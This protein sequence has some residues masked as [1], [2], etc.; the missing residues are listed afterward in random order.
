MELNEK[1]SRLED[2]VK[3]I[4]NEVQAVLLDIRESYLN[5]ENP[6][7][8]DVSSPTLHSVAAALSGQMPGV[9]PAV[10]PVKPPQASLP[11]DDDEDEGTEVDEQPAAEL[12]KGDKKVAA[13]DGL[14]ASKEVSEAM[15]SEE[16]PEV[17]E[18]QESQGKKN[19]HAPGSGK[20]DLVTIAGLTKWVSG[21]VGTFG[22]ARTETILDF[23][24]LAGQLPA[25]LKNT[26]V[27]FVN[28]AP[29]AGSGN[30]HSLKAN[31]LVVSV[32]ELEGLL[33]MNSHSDEL[34]L[35]A[36]VCQEVDP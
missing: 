16:E 31:Q 11:V 12:K 34:T 15:R 2:E 14:L 10:Q 3:V 19:G 30:G 35:L 32:V 17:T 25:E 7:N 21:A 20:L 33:G 23:A 6:F 18:M 24:E 28:R 27:K 22:R 1:V 13:A 9:P 26:L 4:K 5:R 29:E 8:P 36:M